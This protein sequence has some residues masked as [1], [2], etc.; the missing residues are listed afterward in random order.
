MKTKLID[1][2]SNLGLAL[3]LVGS[4]ITASYIE[5]LLP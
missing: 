4:V 3:F 1:L 2:L 5:I